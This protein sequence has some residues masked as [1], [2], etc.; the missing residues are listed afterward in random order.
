MRVWID[1]DL[2]T[3]D[4]LCVDHCPDVF[5][6][7]EDGIAYVAE[8]RSRR[9][10]TR[11]GRAAWPGSQRATHRR[12]DP[13]RRAVPG[14]V[15]LHRGRRAVR[16]HRTARRRSGRLR[17]R[18]LPSREQSGVIAR[19]NCYYGG[20]GN[21]PRTPARRSSDDFLRSRSQQV[22]PRLERRD[23]E[24]AFTPEKGIN[25][26]VVDQISWWKGEPRWMTQHAPAGAA[27][28]REQAD[29]RVVRRQHAR[30]RLPGHLLL[31]AP[32]R[33]AGRRVGRPPRA[34]E[35]ARTRSS[36]SPRPSASTS[37]ASP[38]STSPKSSTT[39]TATTSRSRGSCSATWTPRCAST[40]TWSSSTSA[41]SSRPATTSSPR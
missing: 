19:S 9:S 25:P 30:H 29:G 26:G 28:V 34:D 17:T 14:R 32:G 1:Q 21:Y 6:Q 13:C 40:P 31:P 10:T 20:S 33:R 36:A 27:A 22:R 39:A 2:C 15:H 3:G 7:L 35:G 37:P 24:Y 8:A 23:V 11:A 41:R 38:R 18:E 5:V 16:R 12:R 4:G